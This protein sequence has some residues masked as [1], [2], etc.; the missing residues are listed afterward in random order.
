MTG[1]A[2]TEMVAS[3]GTREVRLSE[4]NR[5]RKVHAPA[6]DESTPLPVGADETHRHLVLWLSW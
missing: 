5:G 4:P 2:E 1:S 3:S 6:A